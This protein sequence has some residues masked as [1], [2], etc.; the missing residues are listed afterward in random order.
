MSGSGGGDRDWRPEPKPA[1]ERRGDGGGDQGGGA[2]GGGSPRADPCNIVEATTLNSVNRT[3]LATLRVGDVLD[4]VFQAG[5]PQ[6]LLAQSRGQTA[7]SITSPSMPQII[8]CIRAGNSYVA[9]IKSIRGALC[10]IE[11]RRR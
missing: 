2:G 8:Q 11:V 4:V 10:R 7:G 6:Q 5:P 3:V 1:P 9:E